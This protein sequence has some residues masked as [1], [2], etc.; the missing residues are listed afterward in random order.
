MAGTQPS[1]SKQLDWPAW[2]SS[3]DIT[4]YSALACRSRWIQLQALRK[5]R[6]LDAV[7]VASGPD[8]S[9][10]SANEVALSWLLLG[11]S[12]RELLSSTV[13]AAYGE[14][15]ICLRADRTFI[16]C[17]RSVQQEVVV[18]TALW[19][20]VSLIVPSEKDEADA[21]RYDA[22]KTGAFIDMVKS[23]GSV[24]VFVRQP[25]VG[26][27]LKMAVERWPL[28]QAF[29]FDDYGHGFLTLHRQVVNLEAEFQ[30]KILP[31]WDLHSMLWARS[32][33]PKLERAWEDALLCYDTHSGQDF[34]ATSP[35]M[36]YFLYGRLSMTDEDVVA[37]REGEGQ[38]AVRLNPAPRVL[39]GVESGRIVAD[40]TDDPQLFV[41][42][43]QHMIW[44]G[45]DP[46]TGIAATRTYLLNAPFERGASS[47]LLAKTRALCRAYAAATHCC[48]EIL[49]N[50]L[51]DLNRVGDRDTVLRQR[52]EEMLRSSFADVAGRP[53]IFCT[54]IDGM[55]LPAEAP[56][57][58]PSYITLVFVRVTILGVTW[59]GDSSP[60]GAVSYG[61][62]IFL[63]REKAT[64]ESATAPLLASL[65][66]LAFWMGTSDQERSMSVKA[67]LE[68][69]MGV[70]LDW[71]PSVALGHRK[72]VRVYLEPPEQPPDPLQL[73]EESLDVA[74]ACKLAAGIR[75]GD[76]TGSL[77][78]LAAGTCWTYASGKVVVHTARMGY[79][80]LRVCG[81]RDGILPAVDAAD[82]KVWVAAVEA[83][84]EVARVEPTWDM[85]IAITTSPETLSVWRQAL[86]VEE[87]SGRTSLDWLAGDRSPV[88]DDFVPVA[89]LLSALGD[90]QQSIL[91]ATLK[92][93]KMT[94]R[95][96]S[97]SYQCVL[98]SG[99]PGSGAMD[100]A[101]ALSKVMRAPLCDLAAWDDRCADLD[102]VHRLRDWLQANAHEWAVLCDVMQDPAEL[103]ELCESRGLS[104]VSHVVCVL[105]PFVA[106]P[107]GAARHP[108]LLSRT[109]RGWVSASFVQDG[110]LKNSPG[111]IAQEHHELCTL[112]LKEIRSSR[113]GEQASMRPLTGDIIEGA[114]RQSPSPFARFL[115]RPFQGTSAEIAELYRPQ[116]NMWRCFVPMAAVVDVEVLR[117]TCAQRLREA[118]EVFILPPERSSHG[119]SVWK[120]LFCIEAKVRGVASGT[121][122]WAQS[123]PELRKAATE[124]GTTPAKGMVLTPKGEL[125]APQYWQEP[126]SSGLGVVFWWCLPN[127]ASATDELAAAATAEVGNCLLRK[128]REETA[129]DIDAVPPS[130]RAKIEEEVRL[131]GPPDGYYFDGVRY[132]RQ[133]DCEVSM[134]HPSFACR[135]ASAVELH[136]E[137]AATR[138]L[139]VHEV[140]QMPLFCQGSRPMHGY[141][142]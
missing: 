119:H 54:E 129:W 6:G 13:D 98:V 29:G 106:Y 140:M 78:G 11:V 135:L 68:T 59:E 85:Q 44:E 110:L 133:E 27:D 142:S 15:L 20:A 36:D 113:G 64:I 97:E 115:S 38:A 9:F 51:S 26:Q 24:G 138:R 35:L 43:A 105:D 128:P 123:S 34:L 87:T 103:L 70:G 99:L 61:D 31:A 126:L 63:T 77:C 109:V 5:S 7:V 141:N 3:E 127:E 21:D 66:S 137:E 65:P 134:E 37:L 93:G 57:V 100:L 88:L 121:T 14:C 111:K 130:L 16:F 73:G 53:E 56:Q 132:I 117:R 33:I 90:V 50:G 25:D 40:G 82:G 91:E 94:S 139:L 22:L 89:A 10:N 42:G 81:A 116:A 72:D 131:E 86:K 39:F 52:T 114:L 74:A 60:L 80:L 1:G 30:Q 124:I 120:G 71:G 45:V 96:W 23:C 101:K 12:G 102:R 28:V 4:G 19:E 104:I 48:R 83:V 136:N 32:L 69:S 2:L 95:P 76:T 122:F 18:R 46:G 112:L 118:T 55:G 107:W 75:T 49:Q 125:R 79:V 47:V 58:K 92:S 108:L 67:D 17:K 84:D 62:S 41:P 8:V